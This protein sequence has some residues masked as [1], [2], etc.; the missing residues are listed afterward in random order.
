MLRE[1]KEPI[2]DLL[3]HSGEVVVG[4]IVEGDAEVD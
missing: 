4:G 1:P 2:A 3:V